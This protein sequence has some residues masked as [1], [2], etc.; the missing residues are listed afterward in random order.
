MIK[1]VLMAAAGAALIA[2]LCFWSRWRKNRR[3][4]AEMS[5]AKRRDEALNEA[6]RNPRAAQS[7]VGPEGPVEISWDDK[8][9]NKRGTEGASLMVE[10]TELSTYSRRKYVFH[11]GPA[12]TIGSSGEN[13][14]ALPRDGVAEKH[15]EI[16]LKDKRF[17]VRSLSGERT[18][19]VRNKNSV[20]VGTEGVYLNDGDHIQLGTAEVQFRKFKG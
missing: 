17:Y 5:Q 7:G 8:T 2:V 19:L 1:Y 9:V 13:Q 14:M 16:G 4:L 3:K 12:I 11:A 20:L 18:V 10:L 15:C 6:L